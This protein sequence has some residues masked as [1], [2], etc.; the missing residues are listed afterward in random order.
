MSAGLRCQKHRP[1]SGSR[2]S[3][4]TGGKRHELHQVC[5]R[6]LADVALI[7]LE[8]GEKGVGGVRHYL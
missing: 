8:T 2:K 3:E 6:G 1:G 4:R 5:R 7:K